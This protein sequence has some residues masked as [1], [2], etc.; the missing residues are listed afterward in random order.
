MDRSVSSHFRDPGIDNWSNHGIK[1]VKLALYE[2]RRE[3]AYV[4]FNAEGTNKGNWFSSSKVVDS[5]WSDLTSSSTYNYF[6]IAGHASLQRRFMINKQ[7]GGCPNDQGHMFVKDTKSEACSW[8]SQPTYPQFIY[9][10]INTVD[11]FDKVL[12]G[13]ADHLAIFVF[14]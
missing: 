10:K 8:D 1:Y 7:Y 5:S 14:I 4:I 2:E 11:F 6:S 13:R 9:S 3:S 12:Y